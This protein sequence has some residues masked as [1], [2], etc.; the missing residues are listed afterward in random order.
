M[1]SISLL[2]RCGTLGALL[3]AAQIAALKSRTRTRAPARRA[4]Q[5][6]QAGATIRAINIT[7]DNVFDPNNPEE[8]KALYRWANRVHV[9]TRETV[10]EDILLFSEGERF[11]A[12]LLD[13]S[14]RALRAARLHL[15]SH[16]RARQLRRR[17]EQRRRQRA[18][19]RLVVARARSEAEPHRRPDRM[20]HRPLRQQFVRH[21]QDARDRLRERHRSR[22]GAARL[23]RRQRVRQPRALTALFA[24]ASD[25]HRRQLRVE[26]PFFSL[27]TR[28]SL[29]GSLHDE[30]RVDTMYDLGEEID[31][32]GHDIDAVE[33]AGRLVARRGRWAARSAGSLGFASEEHRFRT[34]PDVPQPLLLPP[35]RKLV[36]P[37]LGWQWVEDDYREMTELNDMG[38]TEDVSLGAQLVRQRRFRQGALRLGPRRD[39]IR[40]LR[41]ERLGTRRARQAC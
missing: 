20:G 31:E 30:E 19:A 1:R 41:R 21:R 13:E 16:R 10:I 39:T 25:G 29:G 2:L 34:T 32:F 11:V 24:N 8:N 6:E 35:D 15:R 14:A 38:R 36:Y 37:W 28:W 40:V 9:L 7:V 4:L 23:F 33:R 18:R 22:S 26:R 5:L 27:D 3:G 17:H 12:R